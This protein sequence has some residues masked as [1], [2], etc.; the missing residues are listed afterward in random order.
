MFPV[1]IL[2]NPDAE[3]CVSPL[4]LHDIYAQLAHVMCLPEAQALQDP[5]SICG[6]SARHRHTWN[7]TRE[8]ILKAGGEAAESL[9]VM[10]SGILALSL[11]DCPAPDNL[12]DILNA[13]RLG[14]ADGRCLRYYDK[15]CEEMRMLVIIQEI[16]S[17]RLKPIMN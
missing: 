1:Q 5:S 8:E 7:S 9:G 11:D 17:D 12:A 13:V 2:R 4:P 3:G 10:E 15:V 16:G 14:G 6:L